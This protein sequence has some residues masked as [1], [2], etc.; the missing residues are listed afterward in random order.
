[1]IGKKK[2]K[3][4]MAAKQEAER[5]GAQSQPKN[6]RRDIPKKEESEDEEEGRAA[7]FKSKRRKVPKPKPTLDSDDEGDLEQDALKAALPHEPE[8]NEEEQ[9]TAKEAPATKKFYDD[10]ELEPVAK[11]PKAMPSR[12]RAKPTSYLDELLAE[13][14][15]KKQNKAKNRTTEES[16]NL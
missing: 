3:A 14:S 2:A 10:V 7:T 12:S 6:D 11:K 16:R 8:K 5:R 13:R 15:K 4:H 9:E 1:L